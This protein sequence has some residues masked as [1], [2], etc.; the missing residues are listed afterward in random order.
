M[1][2]ALAPIIYLVVGTFVYF[3][4]LFLIEALIKNESFMRCFT[5]EGNVEDSMPITESDVMEER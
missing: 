3:G 2:M 5:S 1:E 4:L